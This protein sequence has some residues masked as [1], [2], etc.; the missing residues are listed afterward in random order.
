MVEKFAHVL[1]VFFKPQGNISI[2]GFIR[3]K[4]PNE[5]Y[6]NLP[7]N[8]NL[9]TEGTKQ[10]VFED[11]IGNN[12]INDFFNFNKDVRQ[13]II[14][15]KCNPEYDICYYFG[16]KNKNN[17]AHRNSQLWHHDSVG[18][19]LKLFI[20]LGTGW[21]TYVFKN[22]HFNKNIFNSS[23]SK[24]ERIKLSQEMNNH[25][26]ATR[27]DLKKGDWVLFDTNAYHKGSCRFQLLW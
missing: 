20:A 4:C 5:I 3:G 23:L 24:V 13:D 11:K 25:R 22:S 17:E 6:D 18:H 27:I 16:T 2:N 26:N 7:F 9:P 10:F 1:D 12:I 14:D 21:T 8:T 15:Y 19:R